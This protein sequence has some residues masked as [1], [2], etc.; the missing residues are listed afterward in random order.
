MTDNLRTKLVSVLT[1][2]GISVLQSEAETDN[3]PYVTFDLPTETRYNKDGPY[4]VIGNLTIRAVSDDIDE[5][6]DL[7]ED[8]EEA[9]AEGFSGLSSMGRD[10]VPEEEV[11]DDDLVEAASETTAPPDDEDPGQSVEVEDPGQSV[12]VEDPDPGN[13]G[14]SVEEINQQQEEPADTSTYTARLTDVRKDCTD[15]NWVIEMDYILNQYE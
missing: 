5:A 6:D 9:I 2:A 3:F 8:I 7:R 15:G 10:E 12:E 14:N 1:E 4:K 11:V 13:A